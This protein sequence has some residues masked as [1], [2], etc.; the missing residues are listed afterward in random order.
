MNKLSGKSADI[1]KENIEKLK[2][3]FPDIFSENR[4]DFDAL[5]A[6]LGE[7]IEPNEERYNFTWSGKTNARVIA[8][9]PT[10]ATLRPAKNESK[11]WDTTKNLYIDGR[12]T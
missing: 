4:I 2:E 8:Q 3:L 1:V 11:N 7:Y 5:K 9:T 12:A 10:T 6:T